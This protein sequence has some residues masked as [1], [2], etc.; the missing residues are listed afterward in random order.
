MAMLYHDTYTGPRWRYGLQ[1]R[2]IS[3]YFL[4]RDGSGDLPHPILFSHRP[5]PGD[6]V[7]PHGVADWPCEIPPDVARHHGLV[8]V[9]APATTHDDA[10]AALAPGDHVDR[11]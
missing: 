7:H 9:A 6:R 2:P 3:A 11:P 10:P 1:H 4:G 5:T 8:L